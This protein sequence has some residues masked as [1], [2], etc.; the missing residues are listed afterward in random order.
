MDMSA[1]NPVQGFHQTENCEGET[2]SWQVGNQSEAER[3]GCRLAS[4][5]EQ[6]L[7]GSWA[8]SFSGEVK[9]SYCY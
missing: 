7:C 8:G 6:P 2:G 3:L 9:G 5:E 4:R 1:L